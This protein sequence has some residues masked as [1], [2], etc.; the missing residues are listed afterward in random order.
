[1]TLSGRALNTDE[2]INEM[3]EIKIDE[4]RQLCTAALLNTGLKQSDVDVTLDHYLENE[5]S[6]KSS[7]GMVRVLQIP[8][9]IQKYGLPTENTAIVKDT[10][11]IV[12]IDGQMNL[13]PVVGKAVLDASIKRAKEHG[14][15]LVGANR[16]L[17]NSGS[18]AYY[19]R[20]L[21]DQGLIGLM[22]C[23]S[24]S[25]VTAPAGKEPFIGTNPIGLGVPCEDGNA[26]IAD[27]AT[28]AIAYGK[29]LVAGAKNES[30]PEGCL[31]DKDGNP[32][33]NPNDAYEDGA[34]LPLADYRGFALGLFVEMIAMMFGGDVFHREHYGKDGLFIIAIDPSKLSDGYAQRVTE[35]L[36]HIRNSP[37]APGHDK[38]SVPGD[39]SH[40]VLETNLKKGTVDIADKTLMKLK[41]LAQ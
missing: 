26:F 28:S 36:T 9:A 11:N 5:I 33:I 24:E 17:G 40:H 22:S 15:S 8:A 32:S 37:P 1:M 27:F 23:N 35:I 14:L 3:T 30:L 18:M 41:E 13:G 7:H 31:I 12:A 10:G 16:Y 25:M 6:G 19:L 39:R 34:I 38:V 29:I 2:D 21:T 20:L 4:L